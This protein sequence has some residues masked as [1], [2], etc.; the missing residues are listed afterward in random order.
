METY[1]RERRHRYF[2]LAAYKRV[3]A[4][5]RLQDTATSMFDVDQSRVG[6]FAAL[7]PKHFYTTTRKLYSY[8]DSFKDITTAKAKKRKRGEEGSNEEESEPLPKRKRGRPRK[9]PALTDVSTPPKKRGRP[10]KIPPAENGEAQN[11]ASGGSPPKRMAQV[12]VE[13]DGQAVASVPPATRQGLITSQPVTETLLGA[14]PHGIHFEQNVLPPFVGSSVTVD[15]NQQS[16]SVTAGPSRIIHPAK[17]STSVPLVNRLLERCDVG[18]GIS[19]PASEEGIGDVQPSHPTPRRSLKRAS[20]SA[21]D[22][23]HGSTAMPGDGNAMVSF[24]PQS[25]KN[26][27]LQGR[28]SASVAQEE[29]PTTIST[30]ST[31]HLSSWCDAT[32]ISN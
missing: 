20:T 14:A 4:S 1:G 19:H 10:R 31:F 24:G 13:R 17:Q 28:L 9:T 29:G 2:T 5:E 6:D 32:A 26:D 22:V 3:V 7:D 27:G 8:Q 12:Y 11:A 21:F 30:V 15:S 25:S 23:D 18:P 16:V